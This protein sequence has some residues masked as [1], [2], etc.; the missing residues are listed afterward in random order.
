[1]LTDILAKRGM[2]IVVLGVV[3]LYLL[4]IIMIIYGAFRDA[5]PGQPGALGP[6]GLTAAFQDA[7]TYTAVKNALWLGGVVAV[8]STVISIVSAWIATN[9]N[10]FLAKMMTPL[11][12]IGL[13]TPPLFF[14]LA[15]NLL[16]TPEIGLASRALAA[17]GVDG[18]SIGG[19]W[20]VAFV[21]SLK[22]STLTYF[23]LIGA[24]GSMDHRM[25][26]A[27]LIFGA[28]P[29]KTF[30]TITLPMMAPAISGALILAFI[31]GMTA[32]DV[33]LL[34]A[35]SGQFPVVS[36]QIFSML[37]EQVP[38]N[39]SAASSL[40]LVLMVTVVLLV[41]VKWRF[42]DRR[43]FSTVGG[44]SSSKFHWD[45]GKWG[46]AATAWIVLYAVSMVI[47]PAVQVI[48][49]SLQ[50]VFGASGA[51]SLRNYALL[52][53]DP[54]IAPAL[55]NTFFL[56]VFGGLIA[57][58]IALTLGLIGRHGTA[59]LRRGLELTT[60]LPWAANGILLGLGL[61]WG[62]LTIPFLTPLFGTVWIVLIGLVI[63]ATPLAARA[64]DGA[65]AQIGK[66]L[67]ESARVSGATA[68]RVAVGIV[69]RLILPSFMAA[70]FITGINIVGNLEVPILLSMPTNKTM[71][72]EVYRLY[73]NGESSMAAALFVLVFVIGGVL[74]GAVYAV[75]WIIGRLIRRRQ[76]REAQA[77]LVSQSEQAGRATVAETANKNFST[78]DA[79]GV[80]TGSGNG[81]SSN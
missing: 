23:V 20:G 14:A 25:E 55:R 72:V 41:A 3:A 81:T 44:K 17:V 64:V 50:R 32:F 34:I 63:S 42:L 80:L 1:M 54:A 74:A 18:F 27:G 45:M 51:L 46:F 28:T 66:E 10:V 75:R 21:L 9:T 6:E 76:A 24:F 73:G 60:W 4:P 36:T 33:P 52:L 56:A 8:M 59:S 29:L 69:L 58:S 31:I 13:A 43:Q 47:L 11:A 61:V 57:S 35:G 40:A 7:A 15:W 37:N 30:L 77:L 22:V 68:L 38:P 49:G 78:N 5:P 2:A 79:H 12:V 53:S 39:Y 16:G 67:E 19:A 26:E 70:W 71:A 65:L 62:F 48:L